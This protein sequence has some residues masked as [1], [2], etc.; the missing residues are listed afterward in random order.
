LQRSN[1]HYIHPVHAVFRFAVLTHESV[2]MQR[3]L[4][5]LDG[6]EVE[7]RYAIVNC[8]A[9]LVG[10]KPTKLQYELDLQLKRC[11]EF[12]EACLRSELE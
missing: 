11:R 8:V 9:S 1:P 7:D 4:D 10:L 6:L 12:K 2:S 3:F 5:L